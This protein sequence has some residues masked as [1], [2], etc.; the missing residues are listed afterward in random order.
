MIEKIQIKDVASYDSLGIK[1]NLKKINY[2]FGSNGTGKTTISEFLR[3]SSDQKFSSCKVDWETAR[4]NSEIFVYNRHFVQENFNVKNEIKGIFTLG[5]ESTDI[6]AEIEEKMKLINK[7]EEKIDSLDN[8]IKER[9]EEIDNLKNDFTNQCWELKLKYDEDFREAFTRL[10][11]NKIN[12]ML[13]CLE[14]AQKNES[15]LYSYEELVKRVESIFKGTKEKI[16]LLPNIPYDVSV[17]ENLIFQTKIIGK[18]DLD[19]AKLIS[20]LYISDWVKQGQQHMNHTD[21]ICPFCQQKLPTEFKDKLEEYFDE[22]YT[23]QIQILNDS[24]E[25]YIDETLNIINKYAFLRD[26]NTPFVN[27][28]NMKNLL[29]V[30]YS[31]YNENVQMLEI[32]KSEPSR[33]IKLRSI[34]TY[35]EEIN[36][37]IDQANVQISE[38][39]RI[40]DNLY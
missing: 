19:I 39:N 13:R 15:D 3:N 4:H 38:H 9:T 17:E 23:E 14:E 33:S 34:L 30:I 10:R 37:Q 29:E 12:F 11:N 27:K 5:K 18:K 21:G 20:S 24:I 6:L 31:T 1:I 8:N 7:H 22:T 32:K 40:L 16:D 25:K 26:E 2:I 36:K 28:E 35:I